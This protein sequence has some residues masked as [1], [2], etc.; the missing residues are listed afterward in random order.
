MNARVGRTR[1]YVTV[2]AVTIAVWGLSVVA[3]SGQG[4]PAPARP[5]GAP[6]GAGTQLSD[7]VFKNVTVMKGMP[8]DQ[9]MGTMGVFSSATGLNCTD[10]H[11]EDS[12]GDW[13]KYADETELKKTTRRMILMMQSINNDNFNGKQVVTCNT[14]HRGVTIPNVM[15]SIAALY[16]SPPPDEPGDPFTQAPKAA[17]P[18]QVL[19]RY[20]AAVG[21]TQRL[22]ALRSISAKGL[23][24]GF[25]DADKSPMEVYANANGQRAIVAHMASGVGTWTLDGQNGWVTGPPT[26]RPIPMMNLT[27]QELEG[28]R[29]E[30]QVFFPANI[31][32]ALRNWRVGFPAQIDDQ[33]MEVVQGTTPSG[34]VVTLCFNKETGLLRRLVRYSGSMVG[35]IV[36]QVDYRDYRD[37][38]GVKLPFAWTVSW[39]NGRSTY[40]LSAV[41]ANP[42]IPP[43]TFARPAAARN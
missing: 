24:K 8:V 26:D 39:L 36:T 12:G 34:G 17:N 10:C 20:I 28:T 5:A 16:A 15:P 4:A 33:D 42:T 11:T 25:D 41:E 31:K 14:C 29:V 9:F 3:M 27:G 13:A 35:R 2:G 6:P 1:L 30:A 19:D 37:V 22:A 23:Y 32:Q 7:Q 18:E 40:E 38:N 43:A 21:G